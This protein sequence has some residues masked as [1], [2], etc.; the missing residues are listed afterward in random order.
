VRRAIPPL[1]GARGAGACLLAGGSLQLALGLGAGAFPLVLRGF[2]PWMALS[3]V[4]LVLLVAGLA[5]MA[6]TELAGS[7]RLATVGLAGAIAGTVI[8]LLAHATAAV[9]AARSVSP[10]FPVGAV[11]TWAGMVLTG[12]AVLRA[13][14]W[15]G[16]ARFLP[17][18]CGLYPLA[19]VLPAYLV[20][21]GPVG[22]LA[23]AGLGLLWAALG[24]GLR[25]T[26]RTWLAPT[27]PTAPTGLDRVRDDP[28][29]GPLRTT[30]SPERA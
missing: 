6:T 20:G 14:R 18:A 7:G 4:A 30:E 10:L 9:D 11:G 26:R 13:R 15:A 5:G 19:V 25:R 23:G 16:P 3:A 24:L 29:T 2:S 12:A 28:P 8:D 17:L 21:D 1:P 27:A 22:H